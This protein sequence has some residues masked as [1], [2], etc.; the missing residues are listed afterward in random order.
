MHGRD[1]AMGGSLNGT[2]D[3]SI[4]EATTPSLTTPR[5]IQC[6]ELPMGDPSRLHSVPETSPLDLGDRL[7]D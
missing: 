2:T 1:L 4:N 6:F 5:S 7:S 3:R